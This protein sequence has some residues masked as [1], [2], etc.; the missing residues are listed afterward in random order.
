MF[1]SA[2]SVARIAQYMG[3]TRACASAI[4]HFSISHSGSGVGCV[5]Q[6]ITITAHDAAHTPVDA[7]ALTLS[8]S[9]S[10]A[11][12]TWTGI[13]SGGGTLN[14]PVAGDGAATYTFPVGLNSVTLLFR[15]TNI[16]GTSETFSF[17]VSGGGFSETTGTAIAADDPPFTMYAAGFRFR[18]ITDATDVVP[19]Q[20]SGKPS[21]TGWNAK[22]I[23]IQAINTDSGSGSCT[24]L[25]ASQT[26][27]VEL[28]RGVQQPGHLRRGRAERQRHESADQRD[29]GGAGATAYTGLSLNFNANSEADTVI[30]YPDA[31]LVSLHARFDLNGAVA[32]YEM[33][34]SSN[35]F[36]VRPFGM[37]FPGVTHGTTAASPVLT[38]GGR[39][40]HDDRHRLR[41]GSPGEDAD[42]DGVPDAGVN[43]TDNG[44]VPNFAATATVSA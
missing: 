10:N 24:N 6:Q 14:D 18:N 12:G 4:N 21:N 23:R 36:V 40:L 19:T 1:R 42:N 41:A 29:N 3:T 20:I 30:A 16:A 27:T 35:S 33:V 43:I 2:L 15:N 9:T 34:G 44:G 11:K 38:R 31:G 26:R 28:G 22:T 13:Q 32:G 5:D 7:N 17:N 39:S 25:F 8:L 37:A